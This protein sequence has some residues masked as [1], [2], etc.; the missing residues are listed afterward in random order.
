[1]AMKELVL[2]I[3]MNEVFRWETFK[4]KC[5]LHAFTHRNCRDEASSAASGNIRYWWGYYAS[6]RAGG[7]TKSAL[8]RIISTGP[9]LTALSYIS[10]KS[11]QYIKI[12]VSLSSETRFP[13]WLP[14]SLEIR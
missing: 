8:N 1:M 3:D 12:F 11:L 14:T 10:F 7:V 5:G 4:K 2:K 6:V 13:T 9:T